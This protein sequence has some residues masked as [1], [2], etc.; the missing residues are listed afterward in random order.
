MPQ[1]LAKLATGRFAYLFCCILRKPE[2]V[3]PMILSMFS[4]IGSTYLKTVFE[5]SSKIYQK[6]VWGCVPIQ[7]EISEIILKHI[8]TTST[9]VL[10]LRM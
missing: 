7:K 6:S 3:N 9:S 10:W 5:K 1:P 8:I 4:K 2:P